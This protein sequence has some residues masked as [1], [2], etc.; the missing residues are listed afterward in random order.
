MAHTERDRPSQQSFGTR[1]RRMSPPTF[2]GRD[3]RQGEIILRTRLMR[4]VFIAGLVLF[5]LFVLF[6]GL[7]A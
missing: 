5:V 6:S 7:T 4:F 3:A 2:K 1:D